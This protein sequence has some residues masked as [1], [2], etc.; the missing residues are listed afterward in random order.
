MTV[1]YK[2]DVF[3]RNVDLHIDHLTSHNAL[4]DNHLVININLNQV[5]PL[6]RL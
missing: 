2:V 4:L 3:Q 1:L 5:E 6:D